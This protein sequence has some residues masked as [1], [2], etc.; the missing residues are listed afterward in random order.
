[1]APAA[2]KP[3]YVPYL[4]DCPLA[5]TVVPPSRTCAILQIAA[6]LSR[7]TVTCNQDGKFSVVKFK[8]QW[9]IF[10]RANLLSSG[11]RSVQVMRSA[12]PDPRGPFGPFEQLQWQGFELLRP[13][14]AN[15]YFAAVRAHPTDAGLLLGLFPVNT[16]QPNTPNGNRGGHI[17]LAL[18]CD[19]VRWSA[20]RPLVRGPGGH[21][22]TYDHPV[23]GFVYFR[24]ALHL[25][26]Q[27]DVGWISPFAESDGHLREY[28]LKP[29][30][31][32][33]LSAEARASLPSCERG[34]VGAPSDFAH[35][36]APR[37]GP[38][39][40]EGGAEMGSGGGLD[41]AGS[42][43]ALPSAGSASSA[44]SRLWCG[45]CLLVRSRWE[46]ECSSTHRELGD[47]WAEYCSC[48]CCRDGMMQLSHLVQVSCSELAAPFR[49]LVANSKPLR[50]LLVRH[51]LARDYAPDLHR[52]FRPRPPDA[53][54]ERRDGAIGAAVP[55][56]MRAEDL[57]LSALAAVL[58]TGCLAAAWRLC[59]RAFARVCHSCRRR[60]SIGAAHSLNE[61]DDA[62]ARLLSPEE[63]SS[64]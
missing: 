53:A 20:L 35:G 25:Y 24:S 27:H 33:R 6:Q 40:G 49:R 55:G 9:L 11:G 41:G 44:L 56:V 54:G 45:A 48:G 63:H 51:S 62:S 22:R 1:M 50:R 5:L 42:A 17:A 15:I 14:A 61:E 43:L 7:A 26:V 23:S 21:G 8:G 4:F 16:G 12:G 30:V 2:A 29:G 39:R 28:T 57:V 36:P 34:A 13:L 52:A 58:L 37:G 59:R 38:S 47:T 18:S 46:R 19:G 3:A 60:D 10:A 31:L 64:S 32:E